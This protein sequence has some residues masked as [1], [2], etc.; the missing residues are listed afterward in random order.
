MLAWAADIR[1]AARAFPAASGVRES[2]QIAANVVAD[3]ENDM[4]RGA[5]LRD[6]ALRSR[7]DR[8]IAPHVHGD[9]CE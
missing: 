2:K 6:S 5:S 1:S 3:A 4:M 7:I 9:F 8:C